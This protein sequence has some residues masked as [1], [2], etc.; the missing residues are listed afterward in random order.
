[1][2]SFFKKLLITF[3]KKV[4]TCAQQI[5]TQQIHWQ[6]QL[7]K[8]HY[9]SV[10]FSNHPSG[11]QVPCMT[12]QNSYC[13]VRLRCTQQALEDTVAFIDSEKIIITD[14]R[15]LGFS[16]S[17]ILA[18]FSLKNFSSAL[19]LFVLFMFIL[20]PTVV[21]WKKGAYYSAIATFTTF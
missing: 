1:M 5:P 6:Y 10:H 18:E 21:D 16:R 3:K 13:S 9:V 7:E 15:K 19:G 8:T 14:P 12:I 4:Q 20:Q 11:S 17:R 2:I